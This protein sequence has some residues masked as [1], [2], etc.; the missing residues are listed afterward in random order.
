MHNILKSL[1]LGLLHVGYA[2]LDDSWQY[3]NV[4]SPFSRLYLITKG[5]GWVFHNERKYNLNAGYL[6]LI[7]SFTYSHYHCD[8][9][10]DQYYISFLEE[11]DEGFSIYDVA[12]FNYE[13][14]ATEIDNQIFSRLLEINPHKAIAEYDPKAYDN[15]PDLLSFNQLNSNRNTSIQ[16][17]SQGILQQLFSRF[18]N[19]FT[20]NTNTKNKHSIHRITPTLRFINRNL[21]QKL[22]VNQL[23]ADNHLSPD[24]FSR[25]FK[26]I[27][28][29]SPIDYIN[30]K[31]LERAQLLLTTTD[32]PISHIAEMCGVSNIHYF[33]RLFKRR[34][35]VPPGRYRT[36]RWKV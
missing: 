7:P 29:I 3:K 35:N 14:K 19:D 28:G 12:D 8:T 1:K 4:I 30:N 17:E 34:F 23:A 26:K 18:I 6:Y 11:T 13:K 36:N 24:H 33:S 9:F 22:T 5:T 32:I 27:M 15:R 20:S 31:R 10:M 16:L 21:N 2:Q 25:M